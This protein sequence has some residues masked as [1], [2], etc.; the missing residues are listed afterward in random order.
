MINHM[1]LFQ[2]IPENPFLKEQKGISTGN[3]RFFL[4]ALRIFALSVALPLTSCD[5]GEIPVEPF[6]RGVVTDVQISMGPTYRYQS[7]FD[8][9][10]DSIIK[11]ASKSEW[12]IAFDCADSSNHVHLNSALGAKAAITS[13]SRLEDITTTSGLVF[14]PDHS[15]G[16][17]DSL[18]LLDC[19]SNQ[20][21]Y[22]IDR[23][24]D[25]FGNLLGIIKIRFISLES[26]TLL[27]EFANL[28]GSNYTTDSLTKNPIYNRIAYSFTQ[29]KSLFAEPLKT[30]FDLLFTQY[31]YIFYEPFI[32]YLVAGVI[33]NSHQ[34]MVAVDS[35]KTFA[36]YQLEDAESMAFSTQPDGIGYDW[37][38]YNFDLGSY[39][40]SSK[41]VFFIRDNEG[42]YYKLRFTDFYSDSGEKGNP[43]FEYLRL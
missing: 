32:Y 16:F 17:T 11:I 24:F 9:G 3:I 40:V 7:W 5:P 37:K 15:A 43:R 23:G 21:V 26:G 28:D 41:K 22:L 29:K 31:T 27:F 13:V 12:D 19:A 35:A 2:L 4:W 1:R 30:Q 18:A 20:R 6:D 10:T 33:I 39:T 34:T 25:D 14:K 8:L 42:F 38:I 36:E